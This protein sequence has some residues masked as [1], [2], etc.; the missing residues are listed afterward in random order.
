MISKGTP[1]GPHYPQPALRLSIW[2]IQAPDVD[3]ET[4][5]AAKEQRGDYGTVFDLHPGAPPGL[6]YVVDGEVDREMFIAMLKIA[7][8][9]QLKR[10]ARALEKAN[11]LEH[12]EP[13][14][15]LDP[16][17]LRET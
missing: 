5:Q 6:R 8:V 15:S 3:P 16:M 11:G 12:D 4:G 10:I 1:T 17:P 14:D 2:G 7:E 9:R 13:E